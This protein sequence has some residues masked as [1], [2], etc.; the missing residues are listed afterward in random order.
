MLDGV[1]DQRHALA[2]VLPREEPRYPLY[3]RLDGLQSWSGW[4]RKISLPPAFNPRIIQAVAS[5]YIDYA[6]PAHIDCVHIVNK[7]K[8]QPDVRV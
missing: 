8:Y 1:G 4:V 5:C 7:R 6:I 2:A 3:S